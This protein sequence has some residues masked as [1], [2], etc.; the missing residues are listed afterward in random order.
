MTVYALDVRNHQ[1]TR[2]RTGEVDHLLIYHADGGIL[3]IC[4]GRDIFLKVA[5]KGAI[6]YTHRPGE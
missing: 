1:P 6:C 5:L 2:G 4:D 3:A